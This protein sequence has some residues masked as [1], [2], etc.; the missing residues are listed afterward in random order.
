[1]AAKTLLAKKIAEEVKTE[2]EDHAFL[3]VQGIES[4][5]LDADNLLDRQVLEVFAALITKHGT[6]K[7]L[8]WLDAIKAKFGA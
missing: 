6:K 8:T 3:T 4:I 1:M 2:V 5:Y 7:V